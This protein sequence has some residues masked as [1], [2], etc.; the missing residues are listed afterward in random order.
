[1]RVT[2]H[3]AMGVAAA[4]TVAAPFAFAQ[5]RIA[6][7]PATAPIAAQAPCPAAIPTYR[8]AVKAR[9]RHDAGAFTQGLLW[10]DGA[11]YESTGQEGRSE[12]RR[13]ALDG[14]RVQARA[15]LPADQFGEGL[16][17]AGNELVAL[18]WK[19]G[20]AHRFDARTLASRGRFAYRG[21]GWGLTTLGDA[22]VRSDG[23]DMLIF[24]DPASF[25]ETRRVAVTMDGVP[26]DALNELETIDGRI[27]ANVWQRDWIA[28]IAPATGCVVA[29]IDLSALVAEIG[30]RDADRVLNGIAF[31]PARRRLFVTGK[32]WPT[33][34]E[35]AL[36]AI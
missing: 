5:D 23:S 22:F 12:V 31:D 9:Y 7:A 24:H 32:E 6:A 28:V 35:I 19:H 10:H 8:P 17:R 29:R 33:L 34:F 18:T 20:I 11:L 30:Y 36:P 25:A 21:E 4:L 27:W 26:L 15:P 13:V 16:A 14:G 3:K 2:R 1:M